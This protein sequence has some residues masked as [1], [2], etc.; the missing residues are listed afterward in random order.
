MRTFSHNLDRVE[1]VFDDDRLVAA[2]LIAPATLA[3]HLGLREVFE[4]HVDLGDA[5]GRANV[6]HKAMTVIHAVLAGADSIDDCGVLRAGAS[7]ALLGHAVAAPSTIGTFLRSFTWGHTRQLDAVAG[8]VLARAWAAGAGPGDEATIIDV[9]SSVCEIYGL[10]KQGATRF[11][12]THVRGY[13]PLFAITAASSDV[14]HSRLRGGNAHTARGAASFLAETFARARAAGA[15]GPLTMRADSGFYNH[16]VVATCAKTGVAFSI[17]VK[18]S[19]SLRGVLSKIAEADWA[20]IP[21]FLEDG[22]DVAEISYRAFAKGKRGLNC[23]LIVRRTKPTPGSQLAL[24]V[25]Y[26]YHAFITDRSGDKVLLDAD[27]R[28]HAV[29]ENAIRDLKVSA[30]HCATSSFGFSNSPTGG[31]L[32]WIRRRLRRPLRTCTAEI[33]PRWTLCKTVWRA[34]PSAAA[35]WLRG[36]HPSG[37]LSVTFALMAS[38][39]RICHGA[40]GVICSPA[41]KPLSNHRY[42]VETLTPSVLAATLIETTSSS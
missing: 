8:E 13:H 14:I 7:G 18:L 38:S 22:A 9:D 41:M 32:T 16:N 2:G 25:D 21:Y 10:Q 24:L 39:T 27:H 20:P 36:S 11:T 15:A 5:P 1:V 6:G 35:A 34:T 17:T 37:A 33:S 26:A 30:Q 29:V 31:C 23:R 12:Y 3:E 4:D 28:R 40:P 42:T 19:K